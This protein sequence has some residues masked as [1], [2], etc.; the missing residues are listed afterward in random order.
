M[1]RAFHVFRHPL[2]ER[3]KD[4]QPFIVKLA[5]RRLGYRNYL[6]MSVP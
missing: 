3:A 5:D 4:S 6:K 1:L 2:V